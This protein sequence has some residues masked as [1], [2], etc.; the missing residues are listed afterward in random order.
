[1]KT[2]FVAAAIA[3][4]TLSGASYAADKAKA[5]KENFGNLA[6]VSELEYS[7]EKETTVIES[8]L[9]YA[10]KGLTLSLLPSYDWDNAK[11]SDVQI[12]ASYAISVTAQITSSPYGEYHTDKD[13]EMTDKIVGIRTRISLF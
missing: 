4:L 1:M 12:A 5:P 8:G 7:I 10:N 9:E 2:L 3:A 11:I 6:I 13:F